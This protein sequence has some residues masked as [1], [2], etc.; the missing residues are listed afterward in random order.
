MPK[1]L[2]PKDFTMETFISTNQIAKRVGLDKLSG[3][4]YELLVQ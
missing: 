3:P 1:E 2:N 4:E